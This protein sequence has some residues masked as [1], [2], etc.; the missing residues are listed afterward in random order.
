MSRSR[1]L[2]LAAALA[3]A[4]CA[5]VPDREAASRQPVIGG[6]VS[7]TA[8]DA[9]VL[10]RTD[11]VSTPSACSGSLLAPN[12]VLTARHCIV[13]DYPAGTIRCN[14][15]GTLSMPSDG[16]VGESVSPSA[17]NVFTG[18]N[19]APDG[20]FP[21]GEPAARGA[22]IFTTTWPTVCRDDLALV[23]LDAA[24]PPPTLTFDLRKQMSP[25]DLVSVVG[26]GL[27]ESSGSDDKYSVRQRRD[28]LRVKYVG[29]LPN[30]FV[31]PRSVCKGD[32]G[33]PAIDAVTGAVLG[34]FSLGFPGEDPATCSSETAL[35]YFVQVNRYE[36]LL[37]EAFDAAGQPFPELMGEGGAGGAEVGAGAAAGAGADTSVDVGGT[38]GATS[39]GGAG[40][41][42]VA[43]SESEPT[44]G[45]SAKRTPDNDGCQLGVA[46]PSAW[47]ARQLAMLALLIG[48]A[49]RRRRRAA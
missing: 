7:D 36:S 19:V 32:S 14:P 41:G 12:L 48:A 8:D 13:A 3:C 33:G 31:L 43:G 16:E 35:N 27:T 29:T 47:G 25:S 22:Q 17:V 49:W 40:S 38:S 6:K 5:D 44:G 42:A 34:V 1:W 37:R 2:G 11:R 9:V 30:T 4:G 24:L 23:V 20:S 46:G 10:L 28:G 15:D 21:G 18:A 39:A 26:Y 45:K